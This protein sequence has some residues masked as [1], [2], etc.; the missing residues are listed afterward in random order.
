VRRGEVR[1]DEPVDEL[2][3]ADFHPPARGSSPVTLADLA[4]HRAGLA[5]VPLREAAQP[6][7]AVDR[8]T[9]AKLVNA[10]PGTR[11]A[12]EYAPSVL[13]Y[14]CWARCSPTAPEPRT[15]RWLASAC[16]FHST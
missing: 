4:T 15:P 6:Y 12:S 5:T 7:A 3:D 13:D 11:A 16:S 9:F 14:A 8:A 2:H 1:L 10:P